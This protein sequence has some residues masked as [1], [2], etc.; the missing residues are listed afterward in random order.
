MST[1]KLLIAFA[2]VVGVALFLSAVLTGQPEYLISSA[3]VTL[4]IAAVIVGE[5]LLSKRVM[6]R[7]GD[8]PAEAVADE[9]EHLPST[10]VITDDDT[11]LGDTPEAHN[12][13]SPRDLPPDHPGRKAAEVQAGG[14]QGATR[15]DEELLSVGPTRRDS[16][17]D[18]PGKS[19]ELEGGSPDL[20]Q[21]SHPYY[22]EQ[23]GRDGSE[24]RSEQE[25]PR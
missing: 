25:A 21:P 12:E 19:E 15:G 8:D 17:E 14:D 7:H 5:K 16:L 2:V 3:L 24:D 18:I 4:V 11:A 23:A 13:I 22:D 1:Q 9:D 6:H 20:E 10:H